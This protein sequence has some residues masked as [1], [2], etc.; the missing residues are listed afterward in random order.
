MFGTD[1]GD[2]MRGGGPSNASVVIGTAPLRAAGLP[3][4]VPDHV[5]GV[6]R[7]RGYHEQG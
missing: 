5:F 2:E 1:Y 7:R 6:Y 4:G 3:D